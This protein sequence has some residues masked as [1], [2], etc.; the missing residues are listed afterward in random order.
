MPRPAIQLLPPRVVGHPLA[1]LWPWMLAAA[2]CTAE[3]PDRDQDGCPDTLD[4]ASTVASADPDGDGLGDDCD[5]CQGDDRTDDRDRDGLCNDVDPDDDGDLCDDDVDVH[6]DVSGAVDFDKDGVSNHCDRCRGDDATGDFDGDGICDNLDPDDDNDNCPD[7]PGEPRDLDPTDT[8]GD[9][10]NDDCDACVGDDAVGDADGDGTC[11]DLD[12]DDDGDGCLDSVD[13]Q[14]DVERSDADGDGLGD[15]C[16]GC[17][18]DNATGDLDGDGTCDDLDGDADGDGCA[19]TSDALLDAAWTDQDD[20][21]VSDDCDL[22]DGEDARGDLDSDGLC[23]D[24]DED[25]DGDGCADVDDLAPAL[26]AV[27]GDGDGIA[28][29]CE[30]CLGDDLLGDLDSDGLCD[31]LDDDDDDDDCADLIDAAPT[32]SSVDEDGDGIPSD[33]DLCRGANHRGDTDGDGVCNNLDSDDDEDG[34][35]D[36]SDTL[37][38]VWAGDGD[39]D[40]IGDHC[41]PCQDAELTGDNDDDGDGV[42]DACDG[43]AGDDATGDLDGDGT[44]DDLDGDADGDGCADTR[45]A[46]LHAA[47]TDGD[48]D[49]V[50]DDCDLCDGEDARGDLDGDGLCDDLDDDDDDD[51]CADVD[52]LAPALA[53]VDSDGDGIAEDCEVCLGDDLL[54]DFDRDGLCDDLD[55]DDD[56][57]SCLDDVDPRPRYTD[58]HDGDGDGVPDACDPC[59]G[60]QAVW[61]DSDGDG[62]CDDAEPGALCNP[63]DFDPGESLDD[64]RAALQAQAAL[65]QHCP[66]HERTCTLGGETYVMMVRFEPGYDGGPEDCDT[67]GDCDADVI[68]SFTRYYDPATGELVA[69]HSFRR[70]SIHG[71]CDEEYWVGADLS[72]CVEDPTWTW[73]GCE[74][75]PTCIPTTLTPS[76][77]ANR[78]WPQW[79]G[80]LFTPDS[81]ATT[82]DG[83]PRGHRGVVDNAFYLDTAGRRG[84]AI[85]DI[86]GD[87]APDLATVHA[88]PSIAGSSQVGLV[89][90]AAGWH[91]G[92]PR[93]FAYDFILVTHAGRDVVVGPGDIDRD[94]FDDLLLAGSPT[95]GGGN[96]YLFFGPVLSRPAMLD[97][98]VVFTAGP[99]GDA[100]FTDVGTLGDLDG[101]GGQEV[102]LAESGASGGGRLYILHSGASVRGLPSVVGVDTLSPPWSGHEAA[103]RRAYNAGDVD[104]DGV[105][106]L[107]LATA[108]ADG[109]TLY[110]VPGPIDAGGDTSQA[111]ASWDLTANDGP[112]DVVHVGDH[113]GDGLPDMLVGHG[114]GTNAVWVVPLVAG[115]RRAIDEA[116]TAWMAR[117]TPW[118]VA[119]IALG[120]ADLTGDGH[121]DVVVANPRYGDVRTCATLGPGFASSDT[122][123]GLVWVLPGPLVGPIDL[124][125]AGTSFLGDDTTGCLGHTLSRV[126]DLDGD[127]VEEVAMGRGDDLF[128]LYSCEAP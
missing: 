99:A 110:L 27:D 57:D 124:A 63:L 72:G 33:C 39:G 108:L 76:G 7:A 97:A 75:Q 2:A 4:P 118:G 70:E 116:A 74:T 48:L 79:S 62:V 40:G 38:L 45:D 86:N 18:G 6:P 19:D 127:G 41:D 96:L 43:C 15:D 103:V 77:V 126:G 90:G 112:D 120:G 1:W 114:L 109:G 47:W 60:D 67:G 105:E 87:G 31:D 69:A 32:V 117:E 119:E 21:G 82:C 104:G 73:V 52:D 111:V 10:V 107:L 56:N 88:Y 16:D 94:G 44:C 25:D 91:P 50:G 37:P 122:Q 115:P 84:V 35:V 13:P 61:P 49:G 8:D 11:D 66:E 92:L 106:D 29:D 46:I 93:R 68:A 51:G 36:G 26:A 98:D 55:D 20:D 78:Y 89:P 59:M 100:A 128:L 17:L 5:L 85:G 95:P 42:D 9:S 80:E 34:C 121:D 24:L 71:G 58:T 83:W 23:A 113:D 14:T 123:Q 54:G 53:A 30:V 22:C 28:E 101:D 3:V 102:F 64:R 125:D 65:H 81:P 12:E